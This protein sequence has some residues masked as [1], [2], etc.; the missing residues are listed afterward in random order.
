MKTIALL[1]SFYYLLTGIDLNYLRTNYYKSVSDKSLCQNMITDLEN[2]KDKSAVQLAYLGGLQ[3]I[4]ANHV[5]SP[6]SKLSTFNE[7]KKNIE[8]AVSKDPNNIEI[9]FVRLSVQ[10]KIPSF[11]GYKS[12]IKED[13][14]MIKNNLS[15]VKS[16][17]LLENIEL[18]LKD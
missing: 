18:L 4:W 13:T 3:T 16:K 5:F 11:L 10:E 7:G 17:Q 14:E 2:D 6:I 8:L 1:C 15:Q 9:R 12:N